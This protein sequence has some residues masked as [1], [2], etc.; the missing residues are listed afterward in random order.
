MIY[1]VKR[2]E[3]QLFT[4]DVCEKAFNRKSSLMI[5]I[6]CHDE[7]R[8]QYKCSKCEE[9]FLYVK[10]LKRHEKEQH[11]MGHRCI[12]CNVEFVSKRNL[13]Q[14]LEIHEEQKKEF[15]CSVCG[16]DF[17]YPS[18]FLKLLKFK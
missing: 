11:S 13:K 4:C 8:T 1:L 9:T 2:E 3:K 12:Y 15:K 14:H 6:K 10:N 17:D 18:Y 5:H 7:N 16:K